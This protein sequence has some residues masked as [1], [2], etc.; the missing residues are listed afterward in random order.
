MMGKDEKMKAS[1]SRS[2]IERAVGELGL[3]GAR[4]AKAV[5]PLQHGD[6]AT[7]A[8]ADPAPAQAVSPAA[9]PSAVQAA[10]ES[11]A[12][13]TQAAFSPQPVPTPT[14]PPEP[15]IQ[16]PV[17]DGKV[18]PIDRNR[19]VA[20][21]FILP[22]AEATNTSEEFRIVKRQLLAAAFGGGRQ[23]AVERG[24]Y[25]LVNSAHPGDGKTWCAVNLALSLAAE[26]DLDVL[27]ID[28]DFGKPSVCK[29]LGLPSGPG[30]MDALVDP[31]TPVE[32]LV[33]RTDLPSLSVLP[34]GRYVRNDTEFVA[35]DRTRHVLDRLAAGYPRR[36]IILDSPP[37]LAASLASELARHVGQTLVVVRADH[38]SDAALR[39]AV[40]L[41][42]ACPN[43]KLLLNGVKF[44]SSGRAF[45]SYYGKSS[46]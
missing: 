7:G 46:G 44:S 16:K 2:L 24:T 4:G 21:G 14:P 17:W 12:A 36:I 26:Q 5:P 11:S 1:S 40:S 45:G 43:V 34:S 33:L 27:L 20:G 41:S 38:T 32:S 31:S 9:G 13:V 37:V 30:F 19:L 23:A 25:V 29:R 8:V 22:D 15:F 35:S 10:A 28:A 3:V 6:A 42:S 18:Y 39:D